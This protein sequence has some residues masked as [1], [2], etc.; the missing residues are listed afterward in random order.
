MSDLESSRAPSPAPSA[1]SFDDGRLHDH[2][3]QHS[4][5]VPTNRRTSSDLTDEEAHSIFGNYGTESNMSMRSLHQIPSNA[6]G[7]DPIVSRIPPTQRVCS[8]T[9]SVGEAGRPGAF[10]HSKNNANAGIL[11]HSQRSRRGLA[12]SVSSAEKNP[13]FTNLKRA[14][15]M[16][17]SSIESEADSMNSRSS[18]ETEEDVCFPMVP[19]HVR[20]KGIDFDEIEEFI[21]ETKEQDLLLAQQQE[22]INNGGIVGTSLNP[23]VSST[24]EPQPSPHKLSILKKYSTAAAKYTPSWGRNEKLSSESSAAST[25]SHGKSDSA[26]KTSED[27]SSDNVKF[28]GNNIRYNSDDI[29]DRFSFFCSGSEETVHAPDFPTLLEPG[30]SA[31]DLFRNG[32]STWWLDCVCPTDAEMRMLTKAFGIHPLTAE[33]IR[34]QETR[35][36]VELFKNYYFV[37]FHSFETDKESEEFLEPINVYMVVFREGI[38]SFHFSPICHPANVRRRVRQLRD[39]VDVSAD[40]LCYALIDDITDGFAPVITAIDYEADAIEESVFARE[41]D[42]ST[43]LLR[44]GDARRRVMTLMRLLT[45]KA[46]VIKMFAK[47]C[48]DEAAIPSNYAPAASIHNYAG[49]HSDISL[50]GLQT[51][52]AGTSGAV[53]VQLGNPLSRAQPRSDIALYLGDIQDHIVTMYQ[54]LMAYEKIFSRSHSNYLAQL[55]ALSLNSN[56]RINE[57]LSKVTLIGT[58]LVPLNVVTGLFGMN[59]TIPGESQGNLKWFFG[60]VGVIVLIVIVASTIARY[61]LSR[62]EKLEYEAGPASR[63]LFSFR[64]KRLGARSVRSL[65]SRRFNRYE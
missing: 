36:K 33:D 62:P 60:I 1:H 49:V 32:E 4:L 64:S 3:Y 30:Q 15:R 53:G 47:R 52:G 22:I 55:Q 20:I 31:C 14:R 5:P 48:Q 16:S 51:G 34:M 59:V 24:N 19:E 41:L 45:N 10:K 25:R 29:P 54:N 6:S 43:M 46:D 37:C 65:P 12:M 2:R 57:M 9:Q 56:N 35:E 18:Q 44:I 17:R 50:A 26:Q 13:R 21:T 8:R 28:T 38:L 39:Y 11:L 61:W 40:W 23:V 27:S 42:F 7:Y 63:S 58:I